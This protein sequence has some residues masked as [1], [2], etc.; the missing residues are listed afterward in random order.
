V[1]RSLLAALLL[2]PALARAQAPRATAPLGVQAVGPVG[3]TVSDLDREV[4]FFTRVLG[5][6]VVSDTEVVGESY[7]RL[8]GLFGVRMRVA[9][10]ALGGEQLELTEYLAPRGRPYPAGSRS[11]DRWFQH[12]AIIVSDMDSAYRVLRANR[13]EH[14]S[15]GPQTIPVSNPAAGG[16]RA[17]Y[18]R[19]PDGHPLEI[20]WFPVGKG[21]DRWQEKDRLFLGIDHTAIVV[22]RSDRSLRFYRDLLGLRVAGQSHNYGTEQAH[23]GNVEGAEVHITGLR[24]PA[25]PGI[26]LLEYAHPRTGRPAPEDERANDLVQVQ[27]T[28]VV[29]DAAAAAPVLARWGATPLSAGPVNAPG[30]GFRRGFL[31][32]DPDGHVLRVVER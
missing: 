10:L 16:I 9:R 5:F 7:E 31:V 28:L 32:R 4:A 21:A 3:L 25:G 15:T 8:E 20:L 14:I 23:L 6:T 11:N 24:A 29:S 26:E 30:L 1:L 12:V 17:F 19:D 27:T 22:E 13:V 2:A 18:F